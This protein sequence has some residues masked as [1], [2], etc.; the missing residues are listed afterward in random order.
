MWVI[1]GEINYLYSYTDKKGKNRVFFNIIRRFNEFCLKNNFG[2]FYGY[3]NL[4]TW[5]KKIGNEVIYE[6]L[7]RVLVRKDLI[8]LYLNSSMNVGIF[9]CSDYSYIELFIKEKR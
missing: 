8:F 1:L 7:D 9:I 4:F 3:G 6:K 5:K 2:N